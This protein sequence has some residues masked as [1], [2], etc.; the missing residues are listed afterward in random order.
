[1][2]IKR[3]NE[4]DLDKFAKSINAELELFATLTDTI[5]AVFTLQDTNSAIELTL[6][7]VNCEIMSKCKKS[8]KILIAKKWREFTDEKFKNNAEYLKLCNK[9]DK[10]NNHFTI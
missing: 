9:Q 2:L 1:M 7:P 4:D 5:Y 6:K 8:T 10:N 3:I